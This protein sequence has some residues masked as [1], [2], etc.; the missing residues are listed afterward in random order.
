MLTLKQARRMVAKS[1]RRAWRWARRLEVADMGHRHIP[2]APYDNGAT[3]YLVETFLPG[4]VTGYL[5]RIAVKSISAEFCGRWDALSRL[6]IEAQD[7]AWVKA[8]ARGLPALDHGQDGDELLQDIANY[9]ADVRFCS[10]CGARQEWERC[11]Q[12]G[13]EGLDGHDCGEDVCCCL[14]P[15]DNEACDVCRGEGGW[16]VCP[17]APHGEAP[18]ARD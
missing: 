16:Y 7:R 9:Y 14:E 17:N 6:E 13:G 3:G 2:G 11:Y 15:E 18:D 12:C 4:V 8:Q 1:R 10:A 5:N